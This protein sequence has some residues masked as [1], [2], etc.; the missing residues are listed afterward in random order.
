MDGYI[1]GTFNTGFLKLNPD[2]KEKN[3]QDFSDISY[4]GEF[5]SGLSK[6]ASDIN[7]SQSVKKLN[8]DNDDTTLSDGSGSLSAMGEFLQGLDNIS[9]ELLERAYLMEYMSEMFNCLTS[10][11]GET[12]LSGDKFENHYIYNGEVEYILYGNSSTLVNK[13]HAISTCLLYTSPSP[14]D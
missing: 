11:E 12:S 9:G 10:K 5:P 1:D 2:E 13:A 14:R 7:S 3:L 8:L 4:P 6:T